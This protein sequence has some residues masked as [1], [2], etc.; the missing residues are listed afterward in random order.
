MKP[1]SI[2]DSPGRALGVALAVAVICALAVS[3]AAVTLR[4]LYLANQEQERMGRLGAILEA[5]AA[6][7]L[8]YTFDD[9]ESR[10]VR[11]ADGAYDD[12]ID[13]GAYDTRRAALEVATST[14]LGP[15]EDIA[16]INRVANHAVVYLARDAAGRPGLVILPVYGVGYQSTLRGYLALDGNANDILALRFYEQGETPGLGS[17]IQDPEWEAL[18]PGK[19]A[20]AA[21]GSV[22]IS[23]GGG[24]GPAANRVDG[25]SGATRTTRGVDA[26]IRFWLGEHGFGPYLH[27]LRGG[28]G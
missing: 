4:P 26:L 7:G 14:A 2:N 23:V 22:A 8:T 28:E 9:I 27:R 1:G 11:L 17:R 16:G 24:G 12:D 20:F 25:I 13:P 21:D 10:A 18:W 5:L 6:R 15:D 19:R 3:L